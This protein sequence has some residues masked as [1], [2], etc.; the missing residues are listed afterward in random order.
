M[1]DFAD[2]ALAEAA[3]AANDP[4]T[5]N[6][7][8]LAHDGDNKFQKAISAWRSKINFIEILFA[9]NSIRH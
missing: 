9:T 1:A 5:E 8:A 7:G 4:Q 3:A 6:Q 2:S